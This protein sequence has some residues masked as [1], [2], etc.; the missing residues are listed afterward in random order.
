MESIYVGP[1]F[2]TIICNIFI[3]M[4]IISV[5]LLYVNTISSPLFVKFVKWNHQSFKWVFLPC[6]ESWWIYEVKS[7]DSKKIKGYVDSD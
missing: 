1:T 5:E 3:K 4:S 7:N 6:S 2:M